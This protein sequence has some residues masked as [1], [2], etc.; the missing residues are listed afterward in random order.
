FI[1]GL[2][3]DL[4]MLF[5]DSPLIGIGCSEIDMQWQG[6]YCPKCQA[7][8]AAGET[9]R[10][11]LLGHAEKCIKAVNEL[12]AELGRPIRP[13]MWG[14][15]F[16][17]YGPGRDWVGMERIPRDVVMGYWKYWP[18]YAGLGG[19]MGRG[20]DV[21]GVPAMYNHTFYLADLSPGDP[22]KS[23]PSMEQTGVR[24]I[25]PLIQAGAE[26][27]RSHPAQE[28]WGSAAASFSKHRLR[29]FDSIWYGFVLNGHCTWSTPERPLEGY[30]DDFTRAFVRHYYD[31]RTRSAADTLADVYGRL[32][33]CK[34]QLELA[35]QTLHDVVGVYDTQEAGY[36]G[37]TLLGACRECRKRIG[38]QGDPD[39]T[40]A[41]IREA[42]VGIVKEASGLRDLVDAQRREVGRVEELADLWLAA[43]KIAAHAEREVLLIDTQ[44]TL[45]LAPSWPADRARREMTTEARRWKFHRKRMER[46][47]RRTSPLYSVGDPCGFAALLRDLVTIEAH[48][49]ELA[50]SGMAMSPENGGKVL[51]EERFQSLDP[52]RWKTLGSPQVANGQLETRAPGGWGHYCGIVSR[53]E[54]SLEEERPLVVEFDLTPLEMG[55][56]SQ[57]FTSA[58]EGGD[59]VSYRFAFYGPTDR[60][61]VFTRSA[62]DLGNGWVDGSAGWRLRALSPTIELSSTYHVRASITRKSLRITVRQAGESVLQLPF[63]DTGMV[64]MDELHST[65]MLWCDVEPEGKKGASRWGPITVW[66][67]E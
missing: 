34:S 51:L 54:F 15:E 50:K 41:R 55:V 58:T 18:D 2:Y 43:E 27:Q 45:A 37:N 61:G 23:W 63:W 52:V 59:D 9:V 4:L 21:L 53:E 42:A 1:K 60:F 36:Q 11:L 16:Y 20:Y 65:R 17:M 19:L 13:L 26:S 35:N 44:T 5:D 24:N 14:D 30:Q 28:F 66:R 39:E 8:V 6:R 25:S 64:P 62:T 7:R 46:I 57:L 48:V 10:D 12:S 32:D 31:A 29:A 49:S 3:R 33:R 22:P 56:D 38:A 40:L 47:L 67:F